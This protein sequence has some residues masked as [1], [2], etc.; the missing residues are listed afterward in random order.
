MS[1]FVNANSSDV[2]ISKVGGK[3]FNLIHMEKIMVN[4]PRWFVLT[5]DCFEA[6][7][8]DN[9]SEYLNILKNY[10]D[11]DRDKILDLIKNIEFSTDLKQQIREE[12]K[13]CFEPND[14]L[15]IRSSAV[16]EDSKAYSFAGMMESYLEVPADDAVFD[17]I[18]KCY[19]SCF[20]ERVM[21][22]RDSNNLI[23]PDIRIA[24]IIQKMITADYAGVVFT[25]NPQTNNPDEVL[26]SVVNGTGEKLVSG[27]CNSSDYVLDIAGEIVRRSEVDGVCVSDILLKSLQKHALEIEKSF[28]PRLAQDIE[29]CIKNDVIYFLQSRSITTHS[30]IDKNAF[31]TILDNSNII[32]SYSGVTTPL[33]YSFAREVYAKVYNQTLK[34]FYIKQEAIDEIQYDLQHMLLFYENRIYYRLN[35]WYRMTSLYPGYKSNKKYMENMMG[36]K[37]SLNESQRQAKTRLIRIYL[38]CL[39]STLRIKKDSESFKEHFE[40]ITRPYYK[41]DFDGF[42]NQQ[43]LNIYHTVEAQILDKFTVPITNDM[44]TMVVFGILTD[45]VKKLP[46]ENSEGV[47]SDILSKQ[48]QVESVGQT[49]DLFDIVRNIKA[50]ASLV[51]VFISEDYTS[52]WEAVR[53]HTEISVQIDSYILHYG[54]RTMDELKLETET[55]FEKPELLLEMIKQYLIIENDLSVY[56]SSELDDESKEKKLY[57]CCGALKR[58][59]LKLLVSVTKFFVRNRESLR[60]RRTYI[61]SIVRKIFLRMGA[62]FVSQGIL[63]NTRDVFYLHKDEVFAFAKNGCNDIPTVRENVRKRKLEMEENRTKTVYER[64]YFYGDVAADNMLPIYSRQ[65][66]KNDENSVLTGVAGG[67]KV[68]IGR[69]KYVENPTDTDVRGYILMAKRTDPG[70]TVLFPMAEAV[71]IERGSVLSH[72]AVVARE[73]GLTLVVGIRGLT[74]VIKDGMIVKVDG[75]NGTV[76]IVDEEEK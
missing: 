70:W 4:V 14:L 61:Y 53:N 6:F 49:L 69:V 20:S 8:G 38:H 60:L 37:V 48:G 28:S 47:I 16:D 21:K 26:I 32:E 34:H 1:I 65:E 40:K 5:T 27:D 51:N 44:A 58:P 59:L 29:F 19:L 63:E 46:V 56:Q 11:E 15:A 57:S 67:G 41:K 39:V 43:L 74:D 30:H 66:V 33:T 22:Y 17:C 68:V 71:I 62:N 50:D 12:I 7:L 18:K 72:S 42:S 3:A 55:M 36:V 73:M 25:S 9:L 64:M 52:I 2:S 45:W 13:R 31:R 23:N 54:A 35:G 76:E 75:V 24:V 10:S